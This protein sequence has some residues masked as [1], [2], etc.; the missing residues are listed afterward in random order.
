MI[1]LEIVLISNSGTPFLNQPAGKEFTEKLW[2]ELIAEF[3]KIRPELGIY[4]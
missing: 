3:R 2:A 4:A 1:C